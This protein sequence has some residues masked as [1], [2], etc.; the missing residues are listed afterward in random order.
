MLHRVNVHPPHRVPTGEGA[1]IQPR[2][3]QA[4]EEVGMVAEAADEAQNQQA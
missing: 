4:A 2:N 3:E 1:A